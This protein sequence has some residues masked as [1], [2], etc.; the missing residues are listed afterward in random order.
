MDSTIL[1]VGPHFMSAYLSISWLNAFL[2]ML[3]I[4]LAI[5]YFFR[6]KTEL[7]LRVLLAGLL[8]ADTICT[9]TVLSS[10]W[11][12]L[13]DSLQSYTRGEMKWTVP[14][15]TVM[16]AIVGVIEELFLLN[17]CRRLF[18]SPLILVPLFA[19]VIAHL[20]LQLY[21]GFY[22]VAFPTMNPNGRRFGN[23]GASIVASIMATV[24]L[25]IPAALIWQ[26]QMVTPLQIRLQR[27]WRDNVMNVISSGGLGA[28]MT[29]I[30]TALYWAR[31]DIWGMFINTMG[32]IYTITILF[33]LLVSR[34]RS[35][36][37][38]VPNNIARK[39]MSF[40]ASIMLYNFTK[41]PAPR[42]D[43]PILDKQ[44]PPTPQETQF[45]MS[46]LDVD[47]EN[48]PASPS[49]NPHISPS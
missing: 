6:Y 24:D 3:E 31:P 37:Y 16:L 49:L 10:T 40:T 34:R 39:K 15:S 38:E 43:S 12:L 11:M 13:I 25:L 2:Y 22:V 4:T 1:S 27:T 8:I 26:I 36:P 48:A 46:S 32:R 35:S 44:L 18:Q 29:V 42:P 14:L 30:L 20:I 33:N 7:S 17:R 5:Y 21:S 19:M 28:I 41:P 9:V 45:N 23:L 47:V